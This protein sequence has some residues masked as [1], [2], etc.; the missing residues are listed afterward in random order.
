MGNVSKK[1]MRFFEIAEKLAQKSNHPKF[2]LGAVVVDKNKI[3]GMGFNK[4]K[5]SPKSLHPWNTRHAELDSILN[6]YREDLTGCQI[7]VFR[8][9]KDGRIRKSLPCASCQATI[10]QMG[11]K[12]IH[13]TVDDGYN[14][15]DL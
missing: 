11:I 8:R 7:Y 4:L 1:E 10:R 6:C 2:K 14:S 12:R 3:I 9:G 13:Y 15:E 5:T